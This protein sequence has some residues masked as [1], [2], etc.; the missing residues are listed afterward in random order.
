MKYKVSGVLL[1]SCKCKTLFIVLF[2]VSS[3]LLAENYGSEIISEIVDVYD[4]DTFRVNIN[5]YPPIIGKS[6]SIRVKGIDAPEIRGKCEY[7]KA[8]AQKAKQFTEQMLRSSKLVELKNIER[9]KYFRILADVYIDGERLAKELIDKGLARPYS[10]GK[11]LG[12]C[13]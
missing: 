3:S 10:G 7:E 1:S 5:G 8:A 11:R 6:I 12:W 13:S 4:A 2:F 9:G